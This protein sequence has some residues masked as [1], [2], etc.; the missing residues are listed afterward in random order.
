[1]KKIVR[2]K[3]CNT[4][5]AT[6]LASYEHGY[7][8]QSNW[9]TEELYRTNSGTYFIYGRGNAASPYAVACDDGGFDSGDSIRVV[10]IESA[11]VWAEKHLDADKYL[12]V[13]GDPEDAASTRLCINISAAARKQLE[14]IQAETKIP[15]GDIVSAAILDYAKR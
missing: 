10:P 2:G 15:F 12:A 13:F 6:K 3:L 14:A 11:K 7:A 5:T 9:Y 4:E 1:M 8:D